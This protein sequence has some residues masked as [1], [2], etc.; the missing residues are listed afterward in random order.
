MTSPNV[1]LNLIVVIISQYICILNHHVVHLKKASQCT[2]QIHTIFIHHLY[3]DKAGKKLQGRWVDHFWRQRTPYFTEKAILE[4][5]CTL[6]KGKNK[7]FYQFDFFLKMG[8][9][10]KDGTN[11]WKI[12][13]TK[14]KIHFSCI[15]LHFILLNEF[16]FTC[17]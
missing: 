13:N 6:G 15:I 4:N 12:F 9:S 16:C 5:F 1:L 3:L 14:K 7:V 2:T 10:N 8:K 11:T 17:C